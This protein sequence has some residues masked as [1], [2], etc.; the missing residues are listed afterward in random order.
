MRPI[1]EAIFDYFSC[2]I[3]F[4]LI[5]HI[6]WTGTVLVLKSRTPFKTS[7]VFSEVENGAEFV[8]LD[9]LLK[10]SDFVIVTCS[11]SPETQSLFDLQKFKLMKKSAIFVN[12]SRGGDY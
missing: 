8:P 10:E 7:F 6:Y 5:A 2:M 3:I 1:I 9:N 12:T 11:L 4:N